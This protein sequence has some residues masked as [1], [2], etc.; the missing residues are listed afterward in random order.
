MKARPYD[1]L[2]YNILSEGAGYFPR[3]KPD[4][5]CVVTNTEE[6]LIYPVPIEIEHIDFV[7][8]LLGFNIRN[9][10]EKASKIVPSNIFIKLRGI[11]DVIDNVTG[12][13]TGISGMEIG[14][15]LRHHAE[16]LEKADSLVEE[17]VR[18]G[19]L[20][21]DPRFESEINRKY[22]F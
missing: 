16:Q 5:L 19:E 22:S 14:H 4:Q 8:R 18:K 15:G 9:V 7:S 1:R 13:D 17:F 20:P 10:P 2:L 11:N 3:K 6:N 12:M 21:V